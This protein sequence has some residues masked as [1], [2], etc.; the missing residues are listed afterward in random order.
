[1]LLAHARSG[2]CFLVAHGCAPLEL[3]VLTELVGVALV[4]AL[5]GQVHTVPPA[6]VQGYEQVGAV[7]PE[8]QVQ[9]GVA[10]LFLQ[11]SHVL[12]CGWNTAGEQQAGC[13]AGLPVCDEPQAEQGCAHLC[14]DHGWRVRWR[15]R[16][17]HSRAHAG[18]PLARRGS[19]LLQCASLPWVSGD[20]PCSWCPLQCLQWLAGSRAVLYSSQALC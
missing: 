8:G 11:V 12:D 10:H 16:A 9:L 17:G 3:L 13:L 5:P 14:G 1:M 18:C 7:V 6:L 2:S 4:L 19:V 15:A 20:I